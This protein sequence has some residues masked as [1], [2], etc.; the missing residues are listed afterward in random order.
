MSGLPTATDIIWDMKRRYYCREENQ[1]VSRQDMQ[2]PSVAARIQAFMN[3]RGFPPLWADD[4]YTTYFEKIFGTDRERQRAYLRGI[5]AE[6]KVMLTAGNRVMGALLA[7]GLTRMMF[8]TNFD[9]V[10]ERAVAE[11]SGRSISAFHLEGTTA[12]NQALANEEWPIYCKLHGDFRFDSVKNLSAD[13]AQ[14]DAALAECM[15]TSAG[16]FG[17]IVA[18]YSGRDDSV[19]NLFRQALLRPNPFPHGLFWTGMRGAPVLPAVSKLIDAA[20][21][22]GTRAAYVE[23][24]TFDA[25]MLRMWRNLPSRPSDL[26]AKVRKSLPAAVSIPLPCHGTASPLLRLNALP[27]ATLP[28]RALIVTPREDIDWA[29]LR[30]IQAEAES[31]ILVTKAPNILCW[32]APDTIAKAFQGH[33]AKIEGVD[34]PSDL[35]AGD[36]LALKGFVEEAIATALA[37][38][39]PLLIRRRGNS[40]ILIVDAHAQDMGPLQPLSSALGKLTGPITGLFAPVDDEHPTPVKVFWAEAVRISITQKNGAAWLLVDPDIWIWP[41][42]ARDAAREFLGE[43]RKDRLNAKFDGI[44]TAWIRVLAGTEQRGAVVELSSF[45]VQEADA[46]PSFTFCSRTAFSMGL[47]G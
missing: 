33:A 21:S 17:F 37:R 39:R 31:R 6:D 40:P 45:Q 20:V 2:L 35:S 1:D 5:L 10:V 36:A 44:L 28:S 11:V 8:T 22:A 3:S 27:I 19:M 26:D 7:S 46:N 14:Q 38:D 25:L 12:A 24:D 32:G 29:S 34:V 43:R 9:S 16:R 41:P 47:E 30:T 42:R 23:I 13:L 4:E 18:G 15:L